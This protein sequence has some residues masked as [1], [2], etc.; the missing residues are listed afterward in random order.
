MVAQ[1]VEWHSVHHVRF[2]SASER[3]N[4]G[5]FDSSMF[6]KILLQVSTLNKCYEGILDSAG[7]FLVVSE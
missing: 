3:R 4:I 2:L 7:L 1:L 5:V 6:S